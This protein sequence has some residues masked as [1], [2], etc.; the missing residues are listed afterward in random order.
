MFSSFRMLIL[1]FKDL[2]FSGNVWWYQ[3]QIRL[4]FF[5][6]PVLFVTSNISRVY[7][8]NNVS[9]IT[10]EVHVIL[11]KVSN[12]FFTHLIY[13][14]IYSWWR[15]FDQIH[16]RL[17]FLYTILDADLIL[18]LSC[19]S[20]HNR[21]MSNVRT[22]ECERFDGFYCVFVLSY[23]FGAFYRHFHQELQSLFMNCFLNILSLCFW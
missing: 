2:I 6:Y 11:S 18:F 10:F 7:I 21:R 1:L 13:I 12:T 23:L 3:V 5:L 14:F 15:Q 9:I 16:F 19:T 22:V 8:I 20:F 17:D 4:Q